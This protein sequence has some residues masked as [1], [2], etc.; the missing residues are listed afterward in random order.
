VVAEWLTSGTV[1]ADCTPDLDHRETLTCAQPAFIAREAGVRIGNFATDISVQDLGDGRLR[2]VVPTRGDPSIAWIDWDGT[3][4][5]CNNASEGYALCDDVHRL[6]FVQTAP[7]LSIPEEPFGVFA[8]SGGEF[9]MVTHLTTGAV[10]LIDSPKTGDAQVTDVA[11]GVFLPDPNTG[12]R[13]ATGIAGRRPASPNG[14]IIYVGSRSEDRI[15]TFTV[16]RPVNG[17]PPFLLQGDWFFLD[18]VGRN[19]GESVDTRGMSFSPTGDKL[20]L[21]NR[22]PPSVQV[23]DTSLDL[24]GFPRNEP[25]GATDICRQAS[26]VAVADTGDGERAY[27]TCF[28]DGQLYIIDARTGV[29]TEDIV[30][31]GRGPYSVV[32][33]PGQAVRDELPQLDHDTRPGSELSDAQSCRAPR[34]TPSGGSVSRSTSLF[35]SCLVGATACLVS[36]GETTTTPASQLNLDR[37]TDITFGCFG[38]MRVTDGRITG[39]VEDPVVLGGQP[40]TACDIRSADVWRRSQ[41]RCHPAEIC[42]GRRRSRLVLVQLHPAVGTRD[43]RDPRGSIQASE[44]VHGAGVTCSTPSP[45]AGKE[46][47]QHRRGSSRSRP[48]AGCGRHRQRGVIR[49]VRIISRRRGGTRRRRRRAAPRSRLDGGAASRDARGDGGRARDRGIRQDVQRHR[50]RPAVHRVSELSPRRRGR[51]VDRHGRRRCQLRRGRCTDAAHRWQRHVPRRVQRRCGGQR[52]RAPGHARS[53]A[54][55]ADRRAS[56]RDRCR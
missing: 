47:H 16:G 25:I 50:E 43:R 20:Y 35:V 51:C 22:R 3:R 7:E 41:R 46:R 45:D 14:D 37:P 40:T 27:V 33:A 2:L 34:R 24:A 9:A 21:V 19:S 30:L 38:P 54:R 39:A 28:Q 29:R 10:T 11:I 36:C 53:R 18:S 55:S 15:Q 26:T 23:F 52:W 6:S 48:T 13:G 56:P 8:H 44:S 32:A 17:A 42:R 31:V 49:S 1:P 4:L 12:L 5:D